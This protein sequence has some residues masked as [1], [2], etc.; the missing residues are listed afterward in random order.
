[1]AIG[2][3][4]MTFVWF[5]LKTGVRPLASR[6]SYQKETVKTISTAKE[7]LYLC[8]SGL[9]PTLSG[10]PHVCKFNDELKGVTE[11][12]S[13]TP[14][15]LIAQKPDRIATAYEYHKA[16]IEVYLSSNYEIFDQRYVLADTDVAVLGERTERGTNES[17][18]VT[19]KWK[20]IRSLG[21]ARLLKAKFEQDIA[22]QSTIKF[23]EYA[24]HCAFLY[25]KDRNQIRVPSEFWTTYLATRFS[26]DGHMPIVLVIGR[27]GS[28]KSSFS[29]LAVNHLP[30]VTPL[31]QCVHI[32]DFD[33]IDAKFQYVDTVSGIATK[34]TDGFLLDNPNE[35]FEKATESVISKIK[36]FKNSS[37]TPDIIFVEISRT[38]YTKDVQ[39][40]SNQGLKPDC[41][42]YLD[43]PFD[44]C[45]QR[46][47]ER[48]N[49]VNG[50]RHVVSSDE[51]E[52]TYKTDDIDDLKQQFGNRLFVF[53]NSTNGQDHLRKVIDSFVDLAIP[54]VI[55]T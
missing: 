20:V 45:L 39:Q 43:A 14:I 53:K 5:V 26:E 7:R 12:G 1:M 21:I 16:G 54:R 52:R 15:V 8:Y 22:A 51:M 17:Y 30:E 48:I 41:V 49:S 32:P 33:Y 37:A 9:Q 11:K 50:D 28:G 18:T 6:R 42:V 3:A 23:E 13:F 46:N 40:M 55:G 4:A 24:K 10:S 25:R 38:S 29:R 47:I 2:S 35:M 31:N 36:A 34:V 44:T 19:T 27:P